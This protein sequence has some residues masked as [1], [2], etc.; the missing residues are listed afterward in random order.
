MSWNK[1][2]RSTLLPW[3]RLLADGHGMGAGGQYLVPQTDICRAHCPCVSADSSI[4]Q[5]SGLLFFIHCP[6]LWW[7]KG[8]RQLPT[9]FYEIMH[10]PSPYICVLS[11]QQ[12]IRLSIHP[13]THRLNMLPTFRMTLLSPFYIMK[14]QEI[15]LA[16]NRS[17][18]V[19]IQWKAAYFLPVRITAG[20]EDGHCYVVLIS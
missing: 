17:R 5:E 20:F 8:A 2:T 6:F 14:K 15:N 1:K 9:T 12:S 4:V 16:Q 7:W 3:E 13:S 11:T 10:C 18:S 19:A